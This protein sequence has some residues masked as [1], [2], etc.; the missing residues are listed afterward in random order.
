MYIKDLPIQYEELIKDIEITALIITDLRNIKSKYMYRGEERKKYG[1]DSVMEVIDNAIESIEKKV[2]VYH[3]SLII[4]T[5]LLDS[6]YKSCND[7]Y[8]AKLDKQIKNDNL[9]TKSNEGEI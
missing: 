8:K 6:N 9:T 2:D 4:G 1:F 3:N 5:D 7:A